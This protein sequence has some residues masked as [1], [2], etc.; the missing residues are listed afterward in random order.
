[1]VDYLYETTICFNT[2]D[3]IGIDPEQEAIKTADFE[4]NYK[5]QC[6]PVTDVEVLNTY[7]KSDK[8]YLEFKALVDG[9]N[10]AWSDVK[11]I[12]GEKDY[13]LI[14]LSPVQL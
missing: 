3:V 12:T 13:R 4:A 11:M 8:T 14:I 9:E 1:M 10:I 6:Y 7:F 2:E 5:S